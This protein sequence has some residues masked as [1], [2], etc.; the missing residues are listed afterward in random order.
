MQLADAADREKCLLLDLEERK[1]LKRKLYEA[2]FESVESLK[3]LDLN[4]DSKGYG[5]AGCRETECHGRSSQASGHARKRF[6]VRLRSVAGVM[7]A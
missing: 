5:G 1:R 3:G 4:A 6:E 7:G 2:D